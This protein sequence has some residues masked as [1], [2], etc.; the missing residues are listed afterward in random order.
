MPITLDISPINRLVVIAASGHI[1]AEDISLISQELIE[2]NVPHYGKIVDATLS[3]SNLTG[4]EVEHIAAMLRGEPGAGRG[5]VAFVNDP[6]SVRF[7]RAFADATH[8]DRPVK[9]F[10][11]LR[12]ARNWLLEQPRIEPDDSRG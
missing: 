11:T 6:E 5:P 1:T 3:T 7:A 9:L 12:E 8:G 2:A 10:R 4:Q